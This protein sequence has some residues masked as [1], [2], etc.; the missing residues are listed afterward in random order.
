VADEN[1]SQGGNSTSGLAFYPA[2]GGTFPAAYDGALLFADYS[3]RCIWAML[4]GSNGL[5]DPSMI[6]AFAQQASFPV[7]LEMGPGGDLLYVDIVDG[8]IRRVHFT[9]NPNNHP[10]VA[11]AHATPRSG[12]VPLHVDFDATGSSD[13]DAGDTLDYAWDLDA[14]G[15]FDDSTSATPSFTYNS[16]GTYAVK[17]RVTDDDGVFDTATVPVY[18]GGGPPSAT[19]TSPSGGGGWAVGDTISFAGSADDPDQG[20][21]PA[22]ALHWDLVLHHCN[23]VGCHE[24]PLQQIDGVASGSFVTPNHEAPAYLELRLTATDDDGNTG[25]DTK[26]LNP[27]NATLTFQTNPPGMNL[28]WSDRLYPTPITLTAI[29]GSS[30]TL[31]APSAQILNNV[32][33]R[34]SGWLDGQA[35]THTVVAPDAAMTYT[36][37]YAPLQPGTHVLSL[38][39]EADAYV[40]QSAGSN[41]GS[42][43]IIRSASSGVES[44]LRFLVGAI[45]G[46]LQSAVLRLRSVNGTADGPA[47]YR[48]TAPWTESGVTWNNRPPPVGEALAD[49]G[50]VAAGA[51]TDLDVTAAITGEGPVNLRLAGGATAAADFH[52]REAATPSNSPALILTVVNDAYPRPKGATPTSLSLVPAYRQCTAP[53]RVHG[54]PLASSSCAPPVQSSPE[55][56]GGTADANGEAAKSVG[57]AGYYAIVGN[58]GTPADEADV[59][60]GFSL[61]DVRLRAGLGDYAGELQALPTLRITDKASTPSGADTGTLGDLTLPVTIPCTPTADASVGSTCAM[62]TTLEAITPG[63]VREGARAI[64]QLGQLEVTDGGPDGDAETPGNSTFARQGLFIP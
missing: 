19:I 9:G 18:P 33:Y 59:A 54:P 45:P 61:G 38:R 34:F 24:H 17:V 11:V 10:P 14:D 28:V 64:W 25:T 35:Q 27:R 63:L 46:K 43:Q 20:P 53:N 5:P 31:S 3:R 22:S 57:S 12:P 44:H 47:V 6:Q 48:T 30:T 50:A 55:L 29:V 16:A 42:A 39:P 40:D 36:A 37:R 2:S 15:A 58:P 56:T 51:T 21:L 52:S 26:Q 41:F 60:F 7:D 32:S 23:S 62:N 13:P 49:A 1:C 4:R 8:E